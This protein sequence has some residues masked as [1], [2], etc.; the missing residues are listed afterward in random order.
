MLLLFK[1]DVVIIYGLAASHANRF[2][3]LLQLTIDFNEN[4]A[5]SFCSTDTVNMGAAL[6]WLLNAIS[7]E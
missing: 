7:E 1:V 3:K 6:N 5:V 4:T 2:A